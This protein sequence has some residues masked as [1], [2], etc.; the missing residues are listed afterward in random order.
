VAY[1][2]KLNVFIAGSNALWYLSFSGVNGSSKLSALESTP[3]LAWYNVTAIRTNGW[4]SDFQI[5]GSEGYNLLPVPFIPSQALF[6]TVGSDSYADASAAASALGSYMLTSF[7]SC[8]TY[9]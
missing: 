1:S 3:G 8:S 6:L 7:V 5:F 4:K 9:T 2:E